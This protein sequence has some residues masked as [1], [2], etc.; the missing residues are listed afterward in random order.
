[1][2]L[3][4]IE[5]KYSILEYGWTVMNLRLTDSQSK[6][7]NLM[8]SIVHVLYIQNVF[9]GISRR[10]QI[11]PFYLVHTV[12]TRGTHPVHF[13]TKC[14]CC[15]F[16]ELIPIDDVWWKTGGGARWYFNQLMWQPSIYTYL[17]CSVAEPRWNGL[18]GSGSWL[19]LGRFYHLRQSPLRE[20]AKKVFF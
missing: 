8:T 13:W 4:R 5:N 7:V 12:H 20:A 15:Q 11:L 3:H 10:F 1:M 18:G 6:R 14:R 17:P 2:S 9:R 19:S 16:I